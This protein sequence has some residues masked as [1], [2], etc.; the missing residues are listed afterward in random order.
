MTKR[1]WA[2]WLLGGVSVGLIIGDVTMGREMRYWPPPRWLLPAGGVVG[3]SVLLVRFIVGPVLTRLFRLGK[4]RQ[5]ERRVVML[6]L[7]ALISAAALRWTVP[8]GHEWFG[9]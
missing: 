3:V 2:T 5:L 8:K 7:M 9:Q 1:Q 6:G 4:E